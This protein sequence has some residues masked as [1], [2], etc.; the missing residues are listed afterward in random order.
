MARVIS[1]PTG[2]LYTSKVNAHSLGRG[3]RVCIGND[4]AGYAVLDVANNRHTKRPGVLW[5]DL[6]GP[7]DGHQFGMEFGVNEP[8]DRVV[9][10]NCTGSAR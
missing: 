2:A 3:D 1:T 8:V 5:I 6:E 9:G 7:A 10:A 4:A